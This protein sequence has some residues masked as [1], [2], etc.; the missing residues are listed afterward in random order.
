MFYLI[1]IRVHSNCTTQFVV[2]EKIFITS[3]IFKFWLSLV[4]YKRIYIIWADDNSTGFRFQSYNAPKYI[5][6]T[7]IIL[8]FY[9]PFLK[10][11]SNC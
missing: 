4:S 10:G 6:Y 2:A 3:E 5:F 9:I 1:Y 11:T 7:L 8:L